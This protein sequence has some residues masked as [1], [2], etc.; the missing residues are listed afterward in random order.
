MEISHDISWE[1]SDP[2]AGQNI[3]NH[4]DFSEPDLS[5]EGM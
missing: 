2:S 3:P 4:F 1:N 5:L